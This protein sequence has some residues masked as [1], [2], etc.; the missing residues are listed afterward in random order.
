MHGIANTLIVLLGLLLLMSVF[1]ITE[2]SMVT[3][4]R[5]RLQAR[6]EE[7]D[8]GARTAM[9]LQE[10]PN[11]FLSTVQIGISLLTTLVAAWSGPRLERPVVEFMAPWLG[12]NGETV[13]FAVVVG[14]LTYV[15]LVL[16]ELVPKRL[17]LRAPES[18]AA[19][20]ARP[21]LL[22]S[23]VARPVVSL[24]SFSTEA[25]LWIL[26]R[27]TTEEEHVTADDIRQMVHEGAEE[28]T[29]QEHEEQLIESVFRM[30]E[31]KIRQI[32]TPRADVVGVDLARSLPQQLPEI[33]ECGYS[34]LPAYEE[35]L[36]HVVGILM[37]KD[38]LRI[39]SGGDVRTLLRPP[40]YV[41]EESLAIQVLKR[42]QRDKTHLA[43][44]VDEHGAFEGV[45]SMED[46][47]EEIVGEIEDEYDK[48]TPDVVESG[49]GEWVVEGG[50]APDRLREVLELRDPFPGELEGHYDTVAG[51]V[52][53]A[54]G[55]IPSQG[56]T[57]HW[58]ALEFEVLTMDGLRIA[59]LRVR[60]R[61]L[62]SAEA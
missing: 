18:I 45:V 25:M 61:I 44:V 36:D 28:G 14:G 20:M 50:M 8:R 10:H 39:P 38:L 37:V 5:S 33:L 32:R 26:R 24:L 48:D 30:G 46:L 17:A 21:M 2:M 29:V 54:L 52:L 27:R 22:L 40:V 57:L 15:E 3:A 34:R 11:R 9:D 58:E 55:H 59:S 62:P 23:R 47:L 31:R 13:A 42:L 12:G 1:V 43:L 16:C 49:S 53:D 60:Q 56:E 6:A 41:H 7:G 35:D 51:F 4:R 19:R